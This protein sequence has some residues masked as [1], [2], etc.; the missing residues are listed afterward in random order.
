MDTDV[1]D[2][3]PLLPIADLGHLI[4]Q[5]DVSPVEVVDTFLDRIEGLDGRVGSF[6]TIMRDEARESARLAERDIAAGIYKGPLHGISLGLKDIYYTKGTRTTGGS[7]IRR[8][9]EFVPAEDATVVGRLREAG[10]IIIGKL[11]THEFASGATGHN[12]HYGQPRN[13]WGLEHVTGGSSGGSGAA[14]AACLCAGALGTD[15]GGSVRIPATLCGITGLKPTYGRLSRY[16]IIPLSWSL[17]HA[18]PMTRTVEDAALMMNAMAGHD[19]RDPASADVPVPDFTSGLA[20]GIEGL[21]IGIPREH[22]FESLDDQVSDAVQKARA[23]LEELGASTVEVSMPSVRHVPEFHSVISQTDAA[24]F[25]EETIRDHAQELTPNVRDRL[26]VGRMTT[27]V[28][29]IRA[30][31]A[32]SVVRQEVCKAL[33]Q[34]DVLVTPTSVVTAPR[35]DQQM[36]AAPG[37]R[38]SVLTLLSRNTAPFNDSGVPACTVPCGFDASGLPIGLQIAGRNFDEVTVLRVANAYQQATDWHTRHPEL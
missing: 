21:R 29:Y 12:P 6:I 34:V 8:W 22:F 15:T 3:L 20:A 14:V 13:P 33:E 18:G 1:R 31:R 11:S 2:K 32:R 24:A 35:I 16:G 4:R 26:E 27:A 36:V 17:D 30:Q 38:A 9:A 37:G 10:A 19:P 7:K 25:H 23:V 28:Q 5:R